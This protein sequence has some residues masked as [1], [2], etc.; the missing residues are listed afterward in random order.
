VEEVSQSKLEIYLEAWNSSLADLASQLSAT[1]WQ[2]K[3]N[4]EPSTYV[5]VITF[6]CKVGKGLQG[7]QYLSISSADAAL[8]LRMFLGEPTEVSGSL[9]ETHLEAMTELLRQWAGLA[10]S[11]LKP[12]FGE[13]SLELEVTSGSR[14]ASAMAEE[15]HALSESGGLAV[16]LEINADLLSMLDRRRPSRPE[17]KPTSGA[18][19]L[20]SLLREGNLDLLL[21]VELGVTLRF[22]SRRA[23]LREVLELSPGAVL[24]LNREI[25]EPVDLMLNERVIAQG[26]VVV[27]DGNYGLQITRVI[28]P[29]QRFQ[30]V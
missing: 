3:K 12:S 20:D 28:S 5:P 29:E 21:E 16:M 7:V 10:A 6:T 1:P 26:D 2:T 17:S 27:I 23:P 4:T 19:S 25:Q 8:L 9:D 11:R 30:A 22:G 24:E 13:V 14:A 15:V 18:N